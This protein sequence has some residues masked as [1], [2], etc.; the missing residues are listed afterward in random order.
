[1]RFFSKYWLAAVSGVSLLGIS[2]VTAGT[3]SAATPSC[4]TACI[5]IFSDQFGDGLTGHAGFLLDSFKQGVATGTPLIMFRESNADPAEDFAIETQGTVSTFSQLGLIG[6]QTALHY[7]CVPSATVQCYPPAGFDL[8]AYE[9]EYAP[10]G[11]ATG[12]C[13]GVAATAVQGEHVTLQPCGV[14]SRTVWIVDLVDGQL[15]TSPFGSCGAF[16]CPVAGGVPLINGSNMNFSHPF[17]LTYPASA[18]PT[19]QPRPV[20]EVANLTGFFTGVFP[21]NTTITA[22]VNSNQ[23][24]DS[25]TGPVQG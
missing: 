2:A 24:W 20:L 3:A 10:Y 11:A 9:I 21:D 1:M 25:F 4:G 8:E 12:Q 17:V 15:G 19:D 14:S 22:D 7:G 13:A 5:G 16:A 6:S 23:L 18:Y